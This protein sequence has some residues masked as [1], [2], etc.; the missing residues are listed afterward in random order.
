MPFML[1]T[2]IPDIHSQE[3]AG[4]SRYVVTLADVAIRNRISLLIRNATS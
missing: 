3:L 4:G 2:V 1:C